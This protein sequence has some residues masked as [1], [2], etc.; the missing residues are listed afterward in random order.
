MVS[1][2]MKP[3]ESPMVRETGRSEA[4]RFLIFTFNT[5]RSP[6]P[7]YCNPSV[8]HPSMFNMLMP[9][10]KWMNHPGTRAT[11]WKRT[12]VSTL[13]K[14]PVCLWT[15]DLASVG[16]S[17]GVFVLSRESGFKRHHISQAFK[18]MVHVWGCMDYMLLLQRLNIKEAFVRLNHHRHHWIHFL[19]SQ[20][21]FSALQHPA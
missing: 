3:P 7:A 8:P 13:L 16:P 15:I 5:S 1:E 4:A 11:I 9:P 17:T 14:I 10:T 6:G 20:I 21:C 2:W 19:F 12:D 18:W